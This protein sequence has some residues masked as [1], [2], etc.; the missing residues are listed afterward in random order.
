MAERFFHRSTTLGIEGLLLNRVDERGVLGVV[1]P[2]V[3]R[4][5][6]LSYPN[7][8]VVQLQGRGW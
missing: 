2:Q 8:E 7:D 3:L 4:V 5:A 6:S 1:R